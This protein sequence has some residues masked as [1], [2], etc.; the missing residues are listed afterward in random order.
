MADNCKDP[1]ALLDYVMDWSDFLDTSN[2]YIISAQAIPVSGIGIP[3]VAFTSTE[4]SFWVSGGTVG[5]QYEVVS[6][7]W[8]NGGRKDDRTYVIAVEEK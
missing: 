7:I 5:V 6:R 3:A 2:D 8:T 4:H 1:D